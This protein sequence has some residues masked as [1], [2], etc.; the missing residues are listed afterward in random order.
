M[1]GVKMIDVYG[2][3]GPSC[4]SAEVLTQMFLAGMTGV[5]LNL[6]HVSLRESEGLL[7]VLHDA[8]QRAGVKPLLLVDLQG[9]ELRI[10]PMG[11]P[12]ELREDEEV[13]LCS[14]EAFSLSCSGE[15]TPSSPGYGTSS[16]SDEGAPFSPGCGTSVCAA[17]GSGSLVD[18]PVPEAVYRVL[19]KNTEV[20]LDDGRLL[21]RVTKTG[22]ESA[23]ARVVRG[24]RLTGRK[25]IKVPG[26]DIR[27]PA[28]TKADRQNVRDALGCGVTGIMQPFVRSREDL[29]EVRGVLAENGAQKLQLVAKIENRA[30]MDQLAELLPAC[31]AVCIARGDLGND[32]DLWQLPAAQ[33]QIAAACR[34]AGKYFMTATQMLSSMEQ[35]A[36]PTRAEV[37]DIF[38]TVA[39]GA[40][41]VMVTGETAVGRYPVEV[42]RYLAKTAAEGE[43]YRE[44][45]NS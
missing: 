27:L 31:D 19:E 35:S 2:T 41:G 9:P 40:S 28:M 36:V 1:P 5:R 42:I 30:G 14:E 16:C 39:D 11:K 17:G 22:E 38:N 8:A 12:A 26:A 3:L 4:A 21:L 32:M 23:F 7:N 20:L 18:I 29:E 25:S 24:G 44:I 6:S 13:R 15:G 34:A 45:L 33:K 37:N 10:G 43:R